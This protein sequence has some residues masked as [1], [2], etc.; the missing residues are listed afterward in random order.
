MRGVEMRGRRKYGDDTANQGAG[1]RRAGIEV[2][3]VEAPST[4]PMR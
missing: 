4:R 2:S 3:T 1:D